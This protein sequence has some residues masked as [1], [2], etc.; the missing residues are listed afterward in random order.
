MTIPKTLSEE[1]VEL[2]LSTRC[3]THEEGFQNL[4]SQYNGVINW[5]DPEADDYAQVGAIR[6]LV[7]HLG[8]STSSLFYKFD[9][10]QATEQFYAAL[11]DPETDAVRLELED[12]YYLFSDSDILILDRLEIS[13]QYRG[14][15]LGLIAN[16]LAI[17][18][19]GR[20][21]PIALLRAFPLQFENLENQ[22][23]ENEQQNLYVGLTAN[24]EDALKR[25]KS[26][27]AKSGFIP[28]YE[29]HI[30]IRSL[31]N[32]GYTAL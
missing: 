3:R 5:Y 19:L 28:F 13:S 17:S 21:C 2:V 12:E 8:A 6:C 18:E 20:S 10:M 7:M 27:Y 1:D 22:A 23:E 29:D 32:S 26:H 9:Q 16:E 14:R 11:V 31:L 24:K 15:K 4:V 25:L 30:M